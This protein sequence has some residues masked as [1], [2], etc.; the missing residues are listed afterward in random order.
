[1]EIKAEDWGRIFED[2]TRENSGMSPDSNQWQYNGKDV[3]LSSLLERSSLSELEKAIQT[4]DVD[5][6][7]IFD[8]IDKK[9]TPFLTDELTGS[10]Q[11]AQISSVLAAAYKKLSDSI[12][13]SQNRAKEGQYAGNAL[14]WAAVASN[15]D[16]QY[17][18]TLNNMK[19]S[20]TKEMNLGQNEDN[21]YTTS[22]LGTLDAMGQMRDS[23]DSQLDTAFRSTE[24]FRKNYMSELIQS[25]SKAATQYRADEE[26]RK[27]E[28]HKSNRQL[29]SEHS[30]KPKEPSF[31]EMV[32]S[33][34]NLNDVSEADLSTEMGKVGKSIIDKY[35][36]MPYSA[37]T[38]DDVKALE[39]LSDK[40]Y[41]RAQEFLSWYYEDRGQYSKAFGMADKLRRN[42]YSDEAFQDAGAERVKK[43]LPMAKK[44]QALK[45]GGR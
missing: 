41:P 35:A 26:E 24:V 6:S 1:M 17:K 22:V 5:N 13:L 27:M 29:L 32:N 10:N 39:G 31:M 45:N 16:P 23:Q 44:E 21:E 8:L 19:S 12:I 3:D 36:K 43:L 25:G 30:K 15:L 7:E 11:Q 33:A 4:A 38:P 37:Y 40:G 14:Y 20:V 2:S 42:P 34:K 18:G 9:L 28:E